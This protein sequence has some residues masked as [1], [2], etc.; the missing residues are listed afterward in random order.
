MRFPWQDKDNDGRPDDYPFDTFGE[1]YLAW[2]AVAL[3]GI[4]FFIILGYII[5]G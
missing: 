1:I 3:T 4:L 2:I 5:G